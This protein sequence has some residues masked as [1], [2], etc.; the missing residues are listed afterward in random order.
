MN[1]RRTGRERNHSLVLSYERL[2]PFLKL[3]YIRTKRYDPIISKRFLH[4]FL[5]FAR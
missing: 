5:F 3:I 4:K 2:K 1:C